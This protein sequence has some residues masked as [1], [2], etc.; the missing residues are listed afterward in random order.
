MERIQVSII[1]KALNE[2]DRIA[3]CLRSA[4]AALRGLAGEVILADSGSIDGTIDIAM[5]YP[6]RI[7]QIADPR[8]ARCGVGPQIGYQFARGDYVYLLDGDMELDRDFIRR[9]LR[10]L[11]RDPALAGVA[12][13]VEELSDANIH[14][15]GRKQRN[16]EGLAGPVPW[17]DMGGLYRVRA[18]KDVGYL[19]NRN[20]HAGEEQELGLRLQARGWKLLRLAVPGVRHYGYIDPTFVLQMKRWRSGYLR[21]P[22]EML[23]ASLGKPWWRS[24]I[25]SQMHLHVALLSWLLFVAGVVLMPVTLSPLLLWLAAC[26]ALLVQRILK[27]RSLRDAL[28]VLLLWHMDAIAMV[29]G[30]LKPQVDPNEPIAT[31]VLARSTPGSMP[32]SSHEEKTNIRIV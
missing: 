14:F 4:L 16:R 24:V 7:V 8:L 15:R 6:V 11:G 17:L 23:R 30:F 27:Y 2:A 9:G 22:G 31:R 1:V 3:A 29:V 20:L 18:I 28:M 10:A 32:R 19:S 21:G 26:L 5:R 12:G 13:L 25:R